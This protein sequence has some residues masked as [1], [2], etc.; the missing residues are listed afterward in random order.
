[1]RV[2]QR[3]LSNR[4]IPAITVSHEHQIPRPRVRVSPP[5]PVGLPDRLV[6]MIFFRTLEALDAALQPFLQDGWLTTVDITNPNAPPKQSALT[7]VIT[8]HTPF[9]AILNR[10]GPIR[11]MFYDAPLME[12]DG[13]Q[14]YNSTLSPMASAPFS[15]IVG[16]KWVIP[17]LAKKKIQDYV[18]IAHAKGI[19]V[20][21]TEPI[22]FP[23]WIRCVVVSPSH[24]P[25]I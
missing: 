24:N 22:D 17:K 1:M 6:L 13:N 4:P 7:I 20:R 15:A 16:S 5:G 19:A 14:T 18:K 21:V 3:G 10:P 25:N 2:V 23:V 11:Y 8:G 12:L 9:Q